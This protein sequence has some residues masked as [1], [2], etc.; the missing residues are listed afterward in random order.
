MKQQCNN[1]TLPINYNHLIIKIMIFI[2]YHLYL[3]KSAIDD[4]C[5]KNPFDREILH[6]NRRLNSTS[7]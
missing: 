2:I 3:K 5:S 4:D 1:I 6:R 7:S